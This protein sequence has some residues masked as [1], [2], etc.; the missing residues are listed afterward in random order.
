MSK[1]LL[2]AHAWQHSSLWFRSSGYGK[3]GNYV[4]AVQAW[5]EHNVFGPNSTAVD[6]NTCICMHMRCRDTQ[7]YKYKS[8]QSF[9]DVLCIWH[10]QCTTVRHLFCER[11]VYI[12]NI[13]MHLFTL[14]IQIYTVYSSIHTN[15]CLFRFLGQQGLHVHPSAAPACCWTG[16]VWVSSQVLQVTVVNEALPSRAVYCRRSEGEAQV[17]SPGAV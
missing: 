1:L 10:T 5:I 2:N 13:C 12:F 11:S 8:L 16:N 7:V 17:A 15:C 14:C 4:K 6:T 3:P 9:A